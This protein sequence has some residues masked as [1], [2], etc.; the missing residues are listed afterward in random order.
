MTVQDHL[1]TVIA[2]HRYVADLIGQAKSEIGNHVDAAQREINIVERDQ[3]LDAEQKTAA[4]DSLISV[5]HAANVGVVSSTAEQVLKFKHWK[6]PK[7]ALEQLLDQKTPPPLPDT[8]PVSALPDT[9]PLGAPAPTEPPLVTPRYRSEPG[10][11]RGCE[12]G[13]AGRAGQTRYCGTAYL[14]GGTDRGVTDPRSHPASGSEPAG[15]TGSCAQTCDV[16]RSDARHGW[17]YRSAGAGRSVTVRRAIGGWVLR[18][19]Q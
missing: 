14:G 15:R 7:N 8:P 19:P 17:A 1:A 10:T 4:I 2:W 16:D 5:A 18:P 13:P 6:A 11:G 9:P 12:S 3:T